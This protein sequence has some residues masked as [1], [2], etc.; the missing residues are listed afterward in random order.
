MLGEKNEDAI[1]KL[2]KADVVQP[3]GDGEA[4]TADPVAQLRY[5]ED[6]WSGHWRAAEH[7]PADTALFEQELSIPVWVGPRPAPA[8]LFSFLV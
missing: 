2:S 1:S 4:P 3:K 8:T 5:Y 7:P 6:L